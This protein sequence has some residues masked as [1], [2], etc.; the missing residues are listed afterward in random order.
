MARV[1]VGFGAAL[2]ALGI[3]G[4]VGSGADSITALIPA[5]FGVVFAVLGFVGQREDRRMLT[6]HLAALLA[7]IGIAGSIMGLVDL[8]D[9][10]AG[11]D[12]ER[13]WAVA[14]QSIMAAGLVV[15]LVMAVRSFIAAR[16]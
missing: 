15:Y 8:P 2:V 4:Y 14:V 7:V 9:L 10:I 12:V 6:M 16:R 3:I 1:T 11:N 13:P 5:F